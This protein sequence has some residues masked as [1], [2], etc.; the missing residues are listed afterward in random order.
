MTCPVCPDGP[1]HLVVQRSPELLDHLRAQAPPCVTCGAARSDWPTDHRLYL[2]GSRQCPACIRADID[3]DM[4]M[5][6]R[7][8]V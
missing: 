7:E 3:D 6:R 4:A 2:P 1:G 5:S 8:D